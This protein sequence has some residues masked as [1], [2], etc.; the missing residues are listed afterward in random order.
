MAPRTTGRLTALK[1]E[2]ARQRGMYADGGG[3]YLRVTT[4]GTKNWVYRFMLD[5]RPRWMGLGPLSLYGLQEARAKVLD[6]RRRRHE[7]IDPIDARRAERSRQRLDTAKAISF[8][9]C[10]E[11]YVEAHEATWKNPKH[12]AQWMMTLLGRTPDGKK[13]TND[14][15][16]LIHDMPVQAVDTSVILRV[17]EPVWLKKPETASRLRGR[18][19]AVLDWAT[20]REFR[21][22]ENPARWRG[23]LD[24]VLPARSKVRK[25]R[26][27]PA[28]PYDQMNEFM[29]D[30]TGRTGIATKA[31]QFTILCAVRTG[32]VIGNDREEKPPMKWSHVDL[33]QRVW[34]IPS[35]KTS[36]EHRVPLSE[37]AAKLLEEVA[38]LELGEIVF[39]GATL[40]E[41]LSN[42]S[43]AS[44]IDRMNEG[45]QLQTLPRYV[46]PK[47]SN[48]DVTVH[49][50]RSTFRTWAAERTNFPREVVEAALAHAVGG[51]TE[52][53]YQRG[54]LFEKRRRLMQQWAA[55]CTSPVDRSHKIVSLRRA[56]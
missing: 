52:R 51:D 9:H 13:T 19:E 25:V 23:H 26:P 55:F 7:G 34:T 36:T 53:A 43:M 29:A 1:V 15:C 49:G 16:A 11:A 20:V 54:D 17:L 35:T 32:D 47:Q 56:S 45:R 12:R 31:L 30:L 5:G 40:G 37:I 41:P 33:K 39:P 48:R 44:V 38:A 4:D 8:K 3:L 21:Q 22:G 24:Q 42:M 50:F 28:L 14:Y 46:D 18:I 2:K 10:A 27:H 6:A